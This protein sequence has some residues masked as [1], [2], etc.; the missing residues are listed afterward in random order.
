MGF[1]VF[2]GGF[3]FFLLGGGGFFNISHG[4]WIFTDEHDVV[5]DA[6][7]IFL[8]L[9]TWNKLLNT[10]QWCSEIKGCEVF[11]TAKLDLYRSTP[12]P[13]N[14]KIRK[15]LEVCRQLKLFIKRLNQ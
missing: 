10:N 5:W 3:C 7:Q 6:F 1:F 11:W 13:V 8:F 4:L 14:D 9:L 15:G 12:Q 2:F